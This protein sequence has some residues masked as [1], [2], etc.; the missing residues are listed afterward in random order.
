MPDWPDPK[1]Q[2]EQIVG[3]LLEVRATEDEPDAAVWAFDLLQMYRAYAER[4]AWRPAV[5]HVRNWAGTPQVTGSAVTD[6]VLALE[7]DEAY[8][9]LFW[10][11]GGH[12]VQRAPVLGFGRIHTSAAM[13]AVLPRVEESAVAIADDDVQEEFIAQAAADLEVA[14][15][16]GL[17]LI[18]VPAG[19]GVSWHNALC[20]DTEA[21]RARELL[22]S[23][24][25]ELKRRQQSGQE[26]R[27][28]KIRTYNFPENRVTDHRAGVSF[29]SLDRIVRGELDDLMDAVA[30]KA[31]VAS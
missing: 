4:R 9:R 13:I 1:R 6:A 18:H 23:R 14:V 30:E 25:F 5:W 31:N 11:T 19:L 20:N 26:M 3:A 27:A 7:S 8:R 2:A 22:C 28:Q 21:A 16:P 10:E 29:Y 24:L 12:R 17:R 15:S